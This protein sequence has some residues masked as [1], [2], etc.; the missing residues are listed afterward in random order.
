MVQIVV[1]GA[2]QAGAALV[3]KLRSG[4]YA[5]KITLIGEEAAP[6][7]QRPPLSQAYLMGE[8]AEERLYLRSA[9][10]YAS[11]DIKLMLGKPVSSIDAAA[12]TVTVGGDSLHYDQLAFTTGSIPRR[13]PTAIGGDLDGV[14]TVRSLG[15]VDAMRSEFVAGRRVVII[16]GGYIGLEAAAVASKLGLDVTVVEMAPRILQRVA[17]PETSDYFRA[18]HASHGVTILEGVGLDRF[19]GDG[20][21]TTARLTDGREL[22][23]DFVIAGVGIVPATLLAGMAGLAI[24]NGI[25]TNARGRTSDPNIW[26]AGD[27]ASFPWRGGGCGWNQC[28][29]RLIKRNWWPKTC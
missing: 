1:I 17:A 29:T 14:Y 7:Y 25:K 12:K 21:V 11:N 19:L 24:D 27:C 9:E 18:L 4:G 23:A 28:K 20:H 8:M 22:P 13:L 15:D 5:G 16:G 3:A 10:Y 2:G 26:A 6:P